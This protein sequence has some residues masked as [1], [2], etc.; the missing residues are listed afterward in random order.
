MYEPGKASDTAYY[1]CA[2]FM[3]IA[4]DIHIGECINIQLNKLGTPTALS[5]KKAS[6]SALLSPEI[7]EII[8]RRISVEDWVDGKLRPC[9]L[10]LCT[11]RAMF[12]YVTI[13][14]I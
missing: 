10:G 8:G 14:V 13:I 12:G 9:S 3:C 11:L 2:L 5:E 1:L 6:E 4:R 7:T